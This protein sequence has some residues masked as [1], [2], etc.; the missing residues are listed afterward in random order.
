M[1]ERVLYRFALA[2]CV[3][4]STFY[5]VFDYLAYRRIIKFNYM[6]EL[7][8]SLPFAAFFALLWMLITLKDLKKDNKN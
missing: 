7:K 2:V 6:Q 4:F 5:I 1:I 8:F 3:Y